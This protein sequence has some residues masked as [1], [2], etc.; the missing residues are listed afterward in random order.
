MNLLVFSWFYPPIVGGTENI[1]RAGVGELVR[2]GHSVTVFTSDHVGA[3]APFRRET[4]DRSDVIRFR[5]LHPRSDSA[6][7]AALPE[8]L[9]GAMRDCRFDLAHT[10][11]LTYPLAPARS[12][13]VIKFIRDLGVPWVDQLHGGTYERDPEACIRLVQQPDYFISDSFYVAQRINSF[14]GPSQ[15]WV[16]RYKAGGV[17]IE[18]PPIEVVYPGIVDAQE[19]APDPER[20]QRVRAQLGLQD[21]FVIFFPSRFFDIDGSLS[22]AKRPLIALSAF[23]DMVRRGFE[24][25]T[26]LTV[27]PPG[28]AAMSDEERARLKV[29]ETIREL[30]IEGRVVMLSRPVPHEEMADLYN[31]ADLCLVPSVEGFGLV[32]IESMACGVPVVGVAEGASCE[33]V[34]DWA[35]ILISPR[36]P[37]E[38]GLGEA[39]AK[40]AHDD[41]LRQRLGILGRQKVA[42][43]FE[44]QGWAEKLELILN[45]LKNRR[46][47]DVDQE[48]MSCQAENVKL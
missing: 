45:K 46:N 9:R 24:Y 36:A 5:G 13:I 7:M 35:G 43:M 2:R 40:L 22:I 30:G 29:A 42:E 12:D 19:F 6:A 31:A 23:A 38:T 3:A 11:L 18:L 17:K 4:L 48:D 41:A 21:R 39:L 44:R 25:A 28:F 37:I 26:L 16:Q 27:M 34:G 20:R 1:A 47:W 14:L 33:V 8:L 15:S 10:H 32:F